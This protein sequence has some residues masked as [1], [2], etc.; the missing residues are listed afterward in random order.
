MEE[1]I[2]SVRALFNK[3]PDPASVLNRTCAIKVSSL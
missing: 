2:I 1:Q 3:L